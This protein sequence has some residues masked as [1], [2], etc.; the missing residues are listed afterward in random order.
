MTSCTVFVAQTERFSQL[1]NVLV[2]QQ[3]LDQFGIPKGG[4]GEA[5]NNTQSA[6]ENAQRTLIKIEETFSY[7]MKLLIDA[8]NYY[9][10]TETVQFLCLVV[11]L[12]YN[13]YHKSKSSSTTTIS[14]SK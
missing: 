3:S 6:F 4:L 14:S 7:H 12:D 10:A 1:L 11:R 5:S 9:S 2:E 8:L 13:Q